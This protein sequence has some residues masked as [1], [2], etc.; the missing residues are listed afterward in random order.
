MRVLPCGDHAALVELDEPQ[1]VLS[2]YTTLRQEPPHGTTE[3]VPAAHTVLIRYDPARTT[4]DR[5]TSDVRRLDLAHAVHTTDRLVEVPVR[6]DGDDLAQVAQLTGMSPRAVI[7]R[8]QASDYT[9]AFSGFAP[10]FAYLTG[11]DPALQVPRH[12]T[13]RTRVPAGAIAL[14]GQFTAVYPRSSPG[15][16][17]IIGHTDLPVWN[18]D[19]DPPMALAPGTRVRFVEFAGVTA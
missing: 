17:R 8:H 14:A 19:H 16:W 1:Q 18:L 15:G 11:L 12:A 9:V 4:I 13:P 6:Y 10:G 5:L 2:L 3:F 7:A